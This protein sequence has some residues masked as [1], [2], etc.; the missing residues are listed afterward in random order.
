MEKQDKRANVYGVSAAAAVLILVSCCPC[1][2]LTTEATDA[3]KDSTRVEYRERV[4]YIPDTVYVDIPE[5][6]A[7]RTTAD[8]VSHLEN[9]LAVS[10]AR[11]LE[12]GALYHTLSV[13][14]QRLQVPTTRKE[15]TRD[16]VVYRD[17]W[18]TVT[19]SVTVEKKLG[20]LD[21]AQIWG[22]R[23]LLSLG[24]ILG[25]GYAIRAAAKRFL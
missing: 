15:T 18:R 1:R 11:I 21:R 9:G 19:K 24:L 23:C 2:H 13:K 14:P 16:S 8:S 10:D 25:A 17:R 7:E 12:G 6:S 3:R 5:R 22:C 4:T 20:W